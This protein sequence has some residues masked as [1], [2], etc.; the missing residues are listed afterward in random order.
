[1][2]VSMCD[3]IDP[4]ARRICYTPPHFADSL[5][6]A[7]KCL[8][9]KTG[10]CKDCIERLWPRVELLCQCTRVRRDACD[11]GVTRV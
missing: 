8:Q 10:A 6:T 11:G 5:G 3:L 7:A 4:L 2:S 9:M 1:M